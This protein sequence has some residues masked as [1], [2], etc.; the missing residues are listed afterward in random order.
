MY[1]FS[2]G[3]K[4]NVYIFFTKDAI[5]Y[6]V[7]FVKVH[8]FDDY[9][10]FADDVYEIIISFFSDSKNHIPSDSR[11][12]P[13]IISIIHYFFDSPNKIL[14]YNC[15]ASDNREKSRNRKFDEWFHKYSGNQYIK[16]DNSFHDSESGMT[17]FSTLIMIKKNP[18]KFYITEAFEELTEKFDNKE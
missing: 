2:K 8:Y 15:D 5:V 18:Y 13:T 11:T 10:L 4:P 3:T 17:F 7:S 1:P 12:A 14:V 9:H 16:L 6:E